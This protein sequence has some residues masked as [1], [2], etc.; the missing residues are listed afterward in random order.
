MLL[1]H[2]EVTLQL[3]KLNF[4]LQISDSVLVS[5]V[6]ARKKFTLKKANK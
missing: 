6:D 1:M 5:I 3:I 4:E 2:Y